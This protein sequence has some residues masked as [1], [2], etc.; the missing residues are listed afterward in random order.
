MNN[1]E[2]AATILSQLGGNRFKVMTGAK[3]FNYSSEG[4]AFLAFQ[5]GR[6]ASKANMVRIEYDE[7][8]DLY[9]FVFL[10]FSMKTGLKELE[11]SNGVYCDQLRE[12]FT[13]YTGLYTSL[14][15]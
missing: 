9:N 4:Q 3:N 10:K 2:V 7:A 8:R 12:I 14:A 1:Q 11:R 15:G 13:R 6:N 5:I